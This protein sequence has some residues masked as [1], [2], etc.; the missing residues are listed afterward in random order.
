M[1]R[2]RLGKD[3]TLCKLVAVLLSRDGLD[4]S[5]GIPDELPAGDGSVDVD[6]DF[7]VDEGSADVVSVGRAL[8]VYVCVCI[9]DVCMSGNGGRRAN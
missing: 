3:S 2:H 9:R 4:G 1:A 5:K 6:V 7:S 8:A